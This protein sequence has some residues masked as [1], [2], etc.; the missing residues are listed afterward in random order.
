MDRMTTEMDKG[1]A[2]LAWVLEQLWLATQEAPDRPCSLARLAKRA[3]RRMSVLMREL[4]VL[5]DA[6]LVELSAREEGGGSAALSP[7]GRALCAELSGA[8]FDAQPPT[9]D[10]RTTL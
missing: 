4:N 6:G 3:Q 7:A 1:E 5:S 9:S 8:W 2:A 10:M